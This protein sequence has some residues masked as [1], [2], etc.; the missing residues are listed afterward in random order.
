MTAERAIEVGNIFKLGTRYSARRSGATYLDAEGE[1]PPD[2]DGLLWHRLRACL[3]HHR[4][5]APRRTRDHL[6]GRRSRRTKSRCCGSAAADDAE[7]QAAADRL[8]DDLTSAGIEVLYDDRDERAGVKFND[9]DLIGNPVRVS[10]SPRTLGK[11][12]AEIKLRSADEAVLVPLAEVK[13]TVRDMLDE[14]YTGLTGDAP[15]VST[16]A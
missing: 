7:P 9:A 3:G 14:L 15:A 12:E 13:A 1:Q 11:G 10:V 8:Y 16:P 5:A 4:R 6:A 2:L